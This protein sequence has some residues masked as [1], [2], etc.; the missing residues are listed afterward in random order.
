MISSFNKPSVKRIPFFCFIWSCPTPFLI[1]VKIWHSLDKVS[2][3]MLFHT[4]L[5]LDPSIHRTLLH[6]LMFNN[7]LNIAQASVSHLCFWVNG[8]FIWHWRYSH[9]LV[10]PDIETS[11][12]SGRSK[13]VL[14]LKSPQVPVRS[15]C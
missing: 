12:L 10:H 15:F 2:V 4:K 8:G 1:E 5:N 14:P 7:W 11:N 3:G 6:V 9:S 13:V